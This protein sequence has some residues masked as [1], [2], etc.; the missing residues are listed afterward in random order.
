M[1]RLHITAEGQ[2]EE[3]FVNDTLK[4]HLASYGVY[5]DVR[6]VLTGKKHGKLYRG[7]MTN[8]AKAKNDI[9]RWLKEERGNGDVAFSTMFDLY[10]L[11]EDFPG[12][13]EAKRLNNPY[14][15]VA[16]IEEAFARDIDDYRFIPYIQLHEFEA[17]LFVNPQLFEIEYFDT[18]EAIDELQ[19][20]TEKFA[21]PELIDQGPE[22]A[23]SKRIIKVLPDYEN[24]KP[25]VGSMIAHEIGIDELRK[26]CA[27][28]NEWLAKLEQ[29][30]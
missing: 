3:S 19:K 14:Q 23:P 22:T 20:I 16:A 1:K 4:P 30:R 25:A 29:L 21:N 15:K 5:A 17:L 24:N 27:H 10:A 18:P 8:Y 26:A 2:T 12:F 11:P 28:F 9:V 13:A 6:R 7:G